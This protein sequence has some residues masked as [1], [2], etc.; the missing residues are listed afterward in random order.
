MDTRLKARLANLQKTGVGRVLV[1]M[2]QAHNYT[3]YEIYAT[4]DGQ[5]RS[6]PKPLA[7]VGTSLHDILELL[8]ECEKTIQD[9]CIINEADLPKHD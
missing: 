6:H 4:K 7:L 5:L 2:R 9:G 8:R 3:L 1:V